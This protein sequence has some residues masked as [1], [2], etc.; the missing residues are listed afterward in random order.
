MLEKA[1]GIALLGYA[2]LGG[3]FSSAESVPNASPLQMT[4]ALTDS[5][6]SLPIF[7]VR[8]TNVGDHDLVLNLGMLLGTRQ[9]LDAIHFSVVGASGRTVQITHSRMPAGVAGRTDPLIVSL[10]LG[11]SFS[12]PVDLGLYCAPTH[13]GCPLRLLPGRYLLAAER[14]AGNAQ[15]LQPFEV[16]RGHTRASPTSFN[17]ARK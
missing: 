5:R 2:L 16:W 8:L 1:Y 12:F 9:Y 6:P 11:A 4:I 3:L 15:G 17:V 13:G 10:P 7:E 14:D